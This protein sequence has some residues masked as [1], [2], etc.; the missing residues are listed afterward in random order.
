MSNRALIHENLII[1]ST[2]GRLVAEEVDGRVVCAGDVLLGRDVLQTE[3]LVPARGE[4]VKGDLA[5]DGE[6]SVLLDT[7]AA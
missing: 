1:I 6:P 2:L 7:N 3:R 5:A 4:D